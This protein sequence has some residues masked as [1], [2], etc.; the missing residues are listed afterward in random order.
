MAGSYKA[1]GIVLHTVKYGESSLVAY[2]F[3][4]VGGRQTYM[5]QGVRSS[6]GRGNK[7]ALFQPMFLL[8][9]EG[10]EQPHAE[11]H[12]MKEVRNLVPLAS[13]PFDVRKSTVSLF[14]AEVLYRL[15]REVE[16]NEPLFDFIC[17]AVQQLDRMEQ[18]VANFHLWFLVR[19]SAYLGFYPGNEYRDGGWFDIRSGLFCDVMPQHRTCMGPASA[20]LLGELMAIEAAELDSLR[21]GRG[22]RLEF[23]EA[24]LIFFGY[25]FDAIHSVQSLRILREVFC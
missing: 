2:L 1:R 20:R 10:I 7:A 18:G 4:D 5:I 13:V 11:M 17:S 23:M 12:R 15:I 14:M 16:A 3:T 21:L 8:E 6:R 22:E 19:L 24:M 25:H 9:F